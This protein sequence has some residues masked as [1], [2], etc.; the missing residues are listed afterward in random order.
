M[1]YVTLLALPFKIN[2]LR[3]RL[4]PFVALQAHQKQTGALRGL[5][6]LFLRHFTRASAHFQCFTHDQLLSS[7]SREP[8]QGTATMPSFLR[9]FPRAHL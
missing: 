5:N 9:Q 3:R 7:A 1:S 4:L 2:K 8:G 6:R